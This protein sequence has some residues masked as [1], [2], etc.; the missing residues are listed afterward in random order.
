MCTAVTFSLT[1]QCLDGTIFYKESILESHCVVC[2]LHF[3]LPLL[4]R[5]LSTNTSAWAWTHRGHMQPALW[6]F[7]VKMFFLHLQLRQQDTPHQCPPRLLDVLHW[8]YRSVI[9]LDPKI[10]PGSFFLKP[11]PKLIKRC[12]HSYR[13]GHIKKGVGGKKT[14]LLFPLQRFTQEYRSRGLRF[15]F[16]CLF[17]CLVVGGCAA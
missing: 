7:L 6:F 9:R 5:S 14:A 1:G 8:R 3:P 13:Q 17:C 2:P 11:C 4:R 15:V 10:G 12:F 16:Y